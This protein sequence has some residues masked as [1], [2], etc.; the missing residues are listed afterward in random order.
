MLSALFPVV[1]V[2]SGKRLAGMVE[3]LSSKEKELIP[4]SLSLGTILVCSN[5][6]GNTFFTTTALLYRDLRIFPP[7][8]D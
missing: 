8:A 2:G 1:S 4:R 7:R 5:S 3:W 6:D